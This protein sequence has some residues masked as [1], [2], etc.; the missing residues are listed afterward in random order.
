[1][2]DKN[3]QNLV[4]VPTDF[5]DVADCA[6]SHAIEIAKKGNDEL[7]LV[8]IVTPDTKTKL[9]KEGKTIAALE[10]QMQQQCDSINKHSG[11][12]TDFELPEGN[13]FT[14]IGETAKSE[15][16]VYWLWEP[17]VL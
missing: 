13:I 10:E 7:L 5:T 1:M 4:L 3:R 12:K 9:K 8:H 2:E 11:I 15:E 6:V 14:T 16:H 17:T